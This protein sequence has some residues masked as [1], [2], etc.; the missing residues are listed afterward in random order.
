M[1]ELRANTQVI[2]TVGPF[3]DVTDG[4]TPQT[5][6]TLAGNEAEL[7]KHGSTTVV[8][9][10]AATWAALADCRG[11]YS[12]TL[13]TSHTD[14]E[15]MLVV[16]VQDDSDCL[17]VKAEYM[18]LSEAAWDSKYV[19]KDDGFMDVNVKTIGRADTQETEA[20]NLEA[21]CAAYSVTRGLT[22]TALPAVAADG[23]GGLPT[24]TKITDARL[25]A[26]TDWIDGGRLDLLLDAIKAK[27][28]LG[29]ENT[30]WTDAKAAYLDQAISAAKTLT[31]AYEAA[32]TAAQAGDA[33]ALTAGERTTL[34]AAIEA[35]IIDE[36]DGTAV[37][38]A[39]ADLIAGDM[40]TGDLSVLAIAAA[41]RDAILDRVLSGNHDGAGTA[42]KLI[43]TA[44]TQPANFAALSIDA[45]GHVS[46]VTLV[47]TTTA[48]TD[49]RGTDSAAL[50]SVCTEPRLAELDAA[51]LP[52]DVA[53]VKTD[54]GNLVTRVTA[55]LFSG[56]TSLAQWL[57]LL[58]GKQTGDATART[59]LR[60]TGAG[61][62]TFDETADSQ[63][64]GRDRGDTAWLTATSVTVSDKTGFSLDAGGLDAISA[65]APGGV[66]STFP[67]MIVQL[68][69]RFFAKA[70]FP[71]DG[72]GDLVSYADDG[73]T[74]ETTQAVTDDDTTQTQGAAT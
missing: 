11:Y 66:A 19:A 42:G 5:D 73:T 61:S 69:R 71:S 30:I 39:I 57:G 18:V 23:A 10:S 48:N 44:A 54:T 59:E 27:T 16:V 15:G 17:P 22:G 68:W 2:V 7:V 41:T 24:T 13:T 8:D 51:N 43:Q 25:G 12:L 1:Q 63:E 38:Q 31:A 55:A 50:A 67:Q 14:T 53:A 74:P 29:L 32:K 45:S 35:A 56:I 36:L 47:D 21:A 34:A 6:I 9:I 20:N 72:N 26:L 40:T 70:T 52:A 46:R 62:G 60:A 3:V 58:A 33:M 37:M 65:A 4:F 49:M 64:A 28:D